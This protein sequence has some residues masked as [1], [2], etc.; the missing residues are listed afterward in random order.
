METKD[1]LFYVRQFSLFSGP[2]SLYVY[3][4]K[5]NDPYHVIGE[6]YYRSQTQIEKIDFVEQTEE[7]LKYWK[8]EDKEIIEWRNKYDQI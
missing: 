3:H 1:Y 5:T 8:Q 7:K 2:N 6:M 4:C